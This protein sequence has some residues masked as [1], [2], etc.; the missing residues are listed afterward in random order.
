M[1][2]DLRILVF[3]DEESLEDLIE[4][5]LSKLNLRCLARRVT[6]R[7]AFLHALQESWHNLILITPGCSGIGG[8]TALALAQDLCPG[9]PCFLINNP[10]RQE[11]A[12]KGQEDQI[13]ATGHAGPEINPEPSISSFFSATGLT[14]LGWDEPEAPL[15]T[16]KPCQPLLET[17]GVIIV[18]LS[19]EGRILEFNRVAERLTGWP[20]HEILG[21]DGLELFFPEIDKK[22][23]MAHLRRVVS[24]ESTESIDLPLKGRHGSTISYRWY[25]NL[26]T[27][28]LGHPAGI[29]LVGQHLP[30]A[31]PWEGRPRARLVRSYSYP[32]VSRGRGL[33]THRAGTC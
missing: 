14:K 32:S 16:Q 2:D 7:E 25:C 12:A 26:I 24:G 3:G 20:R 28:R 18:F 30:E 1:G 11:E 13:N 10:D 31:K 8:L 21:K 23:V 27:D 4:Y 9:T 22:S 33:L 19:L 6:T 5:E 17:A 15:K 29:M